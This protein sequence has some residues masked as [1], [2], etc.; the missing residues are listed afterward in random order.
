MVKEEKDNY[1][2]REINKVFVKA[3]MG[4]RLLNLKITQDNPVKEGEKI[5]V[6]KS[7]RSNFLVIGIKPRETIRITGYSSDGRFA[8][9]YKGDICII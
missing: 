3:D 6:Y 9:Q 8:Y 5:M 1:L 2:E 4:F 7:P